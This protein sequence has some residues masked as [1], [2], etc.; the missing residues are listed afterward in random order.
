MFIFFNNLN[1]VNFNKNGNY[2]IIILLMYFSLCGVRFFSS[3]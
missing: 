3:L 1:N 2:L